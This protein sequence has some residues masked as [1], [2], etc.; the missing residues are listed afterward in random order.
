MVKISE[1]FST[2]FQTSVLQ[3]PMVACVQN[4]F[5]KNL[6]LIQEMVVLEHFWWKHS[7]DTQGVKYT[8]TGYYCSY[9]NLQILIIH[10]KKSE[11]CRRLLRIL[12]QGS[13]SANTEFF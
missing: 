5:S 6:V 2:S 8:T 7:Q 11:S 10:Y 12:P 1:I 3:D 9:L 4:F 13:Y